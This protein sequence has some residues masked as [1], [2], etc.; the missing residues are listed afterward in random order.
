M[1]FIFDPR[2][3]VKFVL[4]LFIV[5]VL[6]GAALAQEK[7]P[8]DYK[9]ERQRLSVPE[10]SVSDIRPALV[11]QTVQIDTAELKLQIQKIIA[12]RKE[13]AEFERHFKNVLKLQREGK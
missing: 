4:A 6:C 8:I 10:V 1:H 2:N 11:L 7:K 13:L 3:F 12:K 5:L 9:A